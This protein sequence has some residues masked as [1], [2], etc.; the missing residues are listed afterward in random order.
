MQ[1][2]DIIIILYFG[3]YIIII[4]CGI[5]VDITLWFLFFNHSIL[6]CISLLIVAMLI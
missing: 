5:Y 6:V 2:N 3:L 4:E 1:R